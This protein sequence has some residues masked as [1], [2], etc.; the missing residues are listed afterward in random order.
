[1]SEA[2]LIA[3]LVA[4]LQRRGVIFILTKD[5]P[6]LEAEDGMIT[7]AEAR[8]LREHWWQLWRHLPPPLYCLDCETR[9]PPATRSWFCPNC[10]DEASKLRLPPGP[11]PL[12]EM[13]KATGWAPGKQKGVA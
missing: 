13:D 12:G 1:M 6:V 7:T 11:D 8:L 5:G 9:L 4:E 10:L 2:D 3:S